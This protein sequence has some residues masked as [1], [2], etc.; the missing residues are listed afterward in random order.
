MTWTGPILDDHF[1]LNR[2]GRY[3]DAVL[4]FQRTGGTDIVL[5]HCPDPRNQFQKIY[6]R[7]NYKSFVLEHGIAPRI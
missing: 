3:L 6:T 7:L 2:N 4:D 1:H 5:V